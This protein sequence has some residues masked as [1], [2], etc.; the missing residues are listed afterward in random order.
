VIITS[1]LC[2]LG[3]KAQE[4]IGNQIEHFRNK[5]KS[6]MVI[7][8]MNFEDVNNDLVEMA[9][10]P[11]AEIILPIH[12]LYLREM[13]NSEMSKFLHKKKGKKKKN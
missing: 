12:K 6:I 11:E 5:K 13:V 8:G 4:G 10:D 1:I 2:Y 7:K 3:G 9:L